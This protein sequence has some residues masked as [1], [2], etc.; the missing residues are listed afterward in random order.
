M[1][2]TNIAL[3]VSLALLLIPLSV[4]ARKNIEDIGIALDRTCIALIKAQMKTG[5]PDYEDIMLLFPD[6]SNKRLSGDFIFKDGMLQRD[7]P[8]YQKHLN[9]Y[10]YEAPMLWVDP[11]NDVRDRI[12]MIVIAPSL[13]LYKVTGSHQKQNNTL[14]FGTD[15]YVDSRCYNSM[16]S[17]EKWLF[18]LGDTIQYLQS[19]CK[20]TNFDSIIK[21]WQKPIDH[22]PK[23][24]SWYKYKQWLENAKLKSKNIFL[25]N[26]EREIYSPPAR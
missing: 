22:D 11:P 24:S 17:A 1:L 19:G 6:T 5:C 21:I 18:L 20:T 26:P 23:S 3:G 7:Q 9:A 10:T 25:V 13:P 8:A 16:I 14:V 15:R 12:K 2:K 4:E